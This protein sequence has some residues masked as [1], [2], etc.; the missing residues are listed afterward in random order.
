MKITETNL[1]GVLLIEPKT[2]VDERGFF[3][4]SYNENIFKSLGIKYNFV[5]DNHS[6]SSRNVLR[7]L[8]FQAKNPQ[9]KLVRCSRG[10]VYDV[11]VDID[12][13]SK[14]FGQHYGAILDDV[15]NNFLFIP[16]GYAHGFCVM[17]DVAD[18]QYKCT[19]FYDP[20]DQEGIAWNDKF[21]GINWP[22]KNPI[23]SKKDLDNPS[24]EMFSEI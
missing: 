21:I 10:S 16:P 20:S 5:Q 13:N 17:S 23:L 14:T 22:T 24:L 1:E 11:A 6:R 19:N 3:L 4:E 8:H 9:G 18:F 7:G 12:P 15:N 2:F